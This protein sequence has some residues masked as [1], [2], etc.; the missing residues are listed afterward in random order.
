MEINGTDNFLELCKCKMREYFESHFNEK[1]E[2]DKC[3]VVWYCKTLQN[4]KAL[5]FAYCNGKGLYG[6]FTFNGDK[7]EL[8]M[9]VYTKIENICIK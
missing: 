8:Y 6:E 9:D 3:S 7:G 4:Y 1:F 5:V 2:G